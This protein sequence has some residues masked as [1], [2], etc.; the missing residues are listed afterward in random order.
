L[1]LEILSLADWAFGEGS[2]QQSAA[3]QS[4]KRCRSA[5]FASGSRSAAVAANTMNETALA[6]VLSSLGP[7]Y[8]LFVS[9][10]SKAWRESYNAV[11]NA[12]FA[13]LVENGAVV[14]CT[15]RMTLYSAVFEFP[16]CVRLARE[17]GLRYNTDGKG[18][19]WKLHRMAGRTA[20]VPA[21]H[22]AIRLGLPI[23]T[24]NALKGAAQ[25]GSVAK[26]QWLRAEQGCNFEYGTMVAAANSGCTAVCEYLRSV[27]TPWSSAVV[28]CA[29]AAG[30]ADTLRWLVEHGCDYVGFELRSEAAEGGHISVLTYVQQLGYLSSTEVLTDALSTA[31]THSKLAAAQWLRQQGTEWPAVLQVESWRGTLSWR[32][33]VLDWARAEGCISPTT[34]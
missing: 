28:D 11:A 13:S 5:G 27:N 24:L 2:M 20:A 15:P 19:T 30:H 17:C 8:Y 7:G 1:Q 10:V 31:G 22:A 4:H 32:G 34:V 16:A 18:N 33:E 14:T 12:Q 21:L 25:S 9:P 23:R 3:T 29:A 26:L 6:L